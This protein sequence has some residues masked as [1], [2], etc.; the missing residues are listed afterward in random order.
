MQL[1]YSWVSAGNKNLQWENQFTVAVTNYVL[2]KI[3]IEKQIAGVEF[4][5]FTEVNINGKLFRAHPNYKNSGPWYDF[6]YMNLS[7]TK[8]SSTDIPALLVGFI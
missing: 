2:Q 3:S 1:D 8:E 5:R 4:I 6:V 7:D